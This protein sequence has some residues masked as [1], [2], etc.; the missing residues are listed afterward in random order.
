VLSI[1]D[2][3]V[4]QGLVDSTASGRINVGSDWENAADVHVGLEVNT[5]GTYTQTAGVTQIDNGTLSSTVMND[6]QGGRLEGNGT[7]NGNTTSDA[8]IAAGLAGAG[9]LTFN[10][11]ML[12]TDNSLLEFELGGTSAGVNFDQLVINGQVTLDGD[13]NL[14]FINGFEMTAL[15]TDFF[16]LL[17]ST[18]LLG[19]F[20]N[21]LNGQRLITSDGLGSFQVNYGVG[22]VFNPN[23]VILSDF[24]TVG[25]PE[26]AL[27]I[28][29]AMSGFLA[30]A[31]FRRRK[32]TLATS[33]QEQSIV[34]A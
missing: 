12:L 30:G 7:V 21:V 6:L 18:M 1:T 14:S 8:T 3:F 25:V 9:R 19:Q 33:S 24:Q 31:A 2:S 27:L 11:D 28:Q 4:N 13:L 15:P 5:T 20:D 17:T 22:S 26:P 16:T 34:A 29:L 32:R 23:H 10:G